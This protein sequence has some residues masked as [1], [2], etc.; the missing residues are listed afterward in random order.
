MQIETPTERLAA[1]LHVLQDC[2]HAGQQAQARDP[3]ASWCGC[4]MVEGRN[5]AVCVPSPYSGW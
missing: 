4:Q 1:G 2:K 5:A 3:P